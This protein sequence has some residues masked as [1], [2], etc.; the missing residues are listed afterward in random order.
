LFVYYVITRRVNRVFHR[1]HT[2]SVGYQVNCLVDGIFD[3]LSGSLLALSSFFV[4]LA[5]TR[6][7]LHYCLFDCVLYRLFGLLVSGYLTELQQM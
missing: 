2:W 3:Q 4:P 7:F 6:D 5:L 1:L